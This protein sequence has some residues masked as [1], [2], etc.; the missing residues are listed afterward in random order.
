MYTNK[1]GLAECLDKDEVSYFYEGVV[2]WFDEGVLACLDKN[3]KDDFN[4]YY[5]HAHSLKYILEDKLGGQCLVY[6]SYLQK[7]VWC[8]TYAPFCYHHNYKIV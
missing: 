5:I 4:W 6:H 3:N 1:L 2:A 7:I 8:E